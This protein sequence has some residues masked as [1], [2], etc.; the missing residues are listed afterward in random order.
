MLVCWLTIVVK[1]IVAEISLKCKD[2]DFRFSILIN[3]SFVL[4]L[5]NFLILF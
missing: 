3:K 2:L 1:M 4:E 5:I